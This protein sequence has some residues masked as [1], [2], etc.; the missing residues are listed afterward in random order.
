M[1]T[2]TITVINNAV[3][4]NNEIEQQVTISGCSTYIVRLASNSNAIGPF[5]VYLDSVIQYS[6]QTRTEMLD[7]VVITLECGTPTPSPTQTPTVTPTNQTPT[8]T[9]THTATPTVTPTN[10][11]TPGVS[12]TQTPTNTPTPSGSGFVAYLF[13]EPSEINSQNNIGQYMSNQG[14]SWFGY[15]NMGGP[16]GAG[17]SYSSNL[18]TYVHFSG[19]TTPVDQFLTP[20]TNF[21]GPIRQTAGSGTDTYGCTQTQY[22]F[23]TIPVTTSQINPNIQYFYSIWIPLAG[24]GG[25]FNNMTV[26][27][28]YGSA[29][30]VTVFDNA[31]PDPGLATQDV[32]VTSGGAIPAG[33]YRVLWLTGG[34]LEQPTSP[35]A[36]STLYIKGDTKS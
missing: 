30:S 24:V 31:I 7:G 15:W 4:C 20:V 32:T 34:A 17:P 26:D 8:A 18:D 23:G 22:T 36:S 3:G 6:A 14:A 10:T 11:A 12:P 16:P 2:Y 9:P 27:A 21:T 1:T 19:W 29:C 33:T 13:P 35:P 5:D 25:T 28:G